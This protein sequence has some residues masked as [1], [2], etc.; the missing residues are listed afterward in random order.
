MLRITQAIELKLRKNQSRFTLE[1]L[2]AFALALSLHLLLFCL[3]RIVSFTS[4]ETV[5]PLPPIAV[6][7]DLSKDE[8]IVLPVVKK[9]FFCFEAP[10]NPSFF[11]NFSQVPALQIKHEPFFLHVETLSFPKIE[12]VENTA[13]Q[14]L[15]S[16]LEEEND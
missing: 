2:K 13:Y 16:V 1:L 10:E 7:V 6:E 11:E 3:F 8:I 9:D 5:S 14:P 15:S 4:V 12:E